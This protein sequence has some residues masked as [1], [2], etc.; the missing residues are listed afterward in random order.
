MVYENRLEYLDLI[1]MK[2]HRNREYYVIRN[3]GMT[4]TCLLVLLG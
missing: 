3:F 2:Y 1:V 4:C